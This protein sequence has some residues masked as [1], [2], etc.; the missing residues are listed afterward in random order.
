[1]EGSE[2]G[3]GRALP[4]CGLWFWSGFW[5]LIP[6][7]DRC[8]W[9]PHSQWGFRFEGFPSSKQKH[10]IRMQSFF[11]CMHIFYLPIKRKAWECLIAKV[12]FMFHNSPARH[13]PSQH[14]GEFVC[15][16]RNWHHQQCN[17]TGSG[18]TTGT[19]KSGWLRDV[20]ST[21][22]ICDWGDKRTVGCILG[23][24]TTRF[25]FDWNKKTQKGSDVIK[26][27]IQTIER[28]MDIPDYYRKGWANNGDGNNGNGNILSRL[29]NL[30]FIYCNFEM[31]R[32]IHS[33]GLY[34]L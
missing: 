26:N 14:A 18:V 12:N 7:S 8:C 1:M 2:T 30:L 17:T 4:S 19:I 15:Q 16:M 28:I 29:L 9:F 3:T 6:L 25:V 5:W 11:F 33:T 34:V 21:D 24:S 13:C 10:F 22:L 27:N 32:A 23:Q 20:Y 31:L